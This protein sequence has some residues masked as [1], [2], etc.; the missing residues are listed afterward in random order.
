MTPTPSTIAA[1]RR[2]HLL[3]AQ[4]AFPQS[5]QKL[6]TVTFRNFVQT[7]SADA[8]RSPACSTSIRSGTAR[9]KERSRT[10]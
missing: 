3:L 7:G 4:P 5:E 9:R 8:L 1:R 6:G 2:S 10:C